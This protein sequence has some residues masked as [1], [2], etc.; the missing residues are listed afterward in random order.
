LREL[1]CAAVA[2]ESRASRAGECGQDAAGS[3]AIDP[4][5]AEVGNV[6][7]AIGRD[8]DVARL[9]EL[10]AGS[11]STIAIAAWRDGPTSGD[12]RNRAAGRDSSNAPIAEVRDVEIALRIDNH[13]I[14]MAEH[15]RVGGPAIP[16][17]SRHAGT[18]HGL[19]AAV[20]VYLSNSVVIGIG[21]V[22]R[23][24]A[25]DGNSF[26]LAEYRC[27]SGWAVRGKVAARDGLDDI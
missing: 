23:A 6:E 26:G 17:E 24:A 25:V 11:R 22:N 12:G 20:G 1:R 15:G 10:H 9:E 16:R 18:C 21:N 8:G 19:N 14:G 2:G 5:R 27:Q 4:V 13:S 3:D 7:R